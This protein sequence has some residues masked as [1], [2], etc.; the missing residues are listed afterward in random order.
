MT[1]RMISLVLGDAVHALCLPRSQTQPHCKGSTHVEGLHG[2]HMS[3]VCMVNTCRGFAGS[4]RLESLQGLHVSRVCMVYTCRGFAWSTRVDRLH[5][6]QLP[7][8]S[9]EKPQS[10]EDLLTQVSSIIWHIRLK[11]QLQAIIYSYTTATAVNWE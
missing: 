10:A 2:R 3:R 5:G 8:L 6:R 4:T 7:T 1:S 9:K 11:T